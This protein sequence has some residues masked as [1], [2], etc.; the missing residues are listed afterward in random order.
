[1]NINDIYEALKKLDSKLNSI[2]EQ[3]SNIV[4]TDV[5]LPMAERKEK[6]ADLI[7]EFNKFN[8]LKRELLRLDIE[9]SAEVERKVKFVNSLEI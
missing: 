5:Y 4:M 6:K 8:L 3:Y 2:K 9:W 1:M 7:V